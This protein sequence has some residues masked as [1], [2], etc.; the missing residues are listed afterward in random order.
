MTMTQSWGHNNRP[1]YKSAERLIHTLVDVVAKGGNFL[2]N[3]GPTPE[4]TWQAAAYERLAAI[5]EW[6]DVNGE[7]IYA[8]RPYEVYE[9]GSTLR[10]TQSKDS[11]TVYVF[12]LDW[13][14]DT[15][16]VR[17][18]RAMQDA[19]I[20]LLGREEPLQWSQDDRE[21]QIALPAESKRVSNWAWT[22]RVERE[23][24]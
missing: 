3:I 10:F 13:P 9:E 21:L 22:V 16:R 23:V 4:G 20:V 12:A 24:R 1:Q 17:S 18:V 7:G 5:G 15:L 2:L 8:T 19:E 6:M 14:G 11:R